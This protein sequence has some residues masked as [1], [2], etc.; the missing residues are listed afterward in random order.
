MFA[1]WNGFNFGDDQALRLDSS[2]R[3][4]KVLNSA[5][6]SAWDVR[7]IRRVHA[8][9]GIAVNAAVRNNSPALIT[10]GWLQIWTKNICKPFYAQLGQ[11]KTNPA[12]TRLIFCPLTAPCE[13]S[14][15]DLSLATS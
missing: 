9:E 13:D 1:S 7:H 8:N 15:S 14:N 11:E 12:K 6:S 10:L 2:I 3:S 4:N 5:V